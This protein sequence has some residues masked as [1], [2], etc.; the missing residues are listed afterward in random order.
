MDE[1]TARRL[2]LELMSLAK[3]A[4]LTTI[5]RDGYPETR[6]ISN[7]RNEEMFG[8]LSTLFAEHDNDF[9]VYFSTNTSSNKVAQIRANP[10]VSVYFC[11]PEQWRGL[12]LGG[13]M[14][15]SNDPELKKAIWQD[16]WELY[17]PTGP[18]DPGYSI[19]KLIPEIA[20]YY[21]QL[22]TTEFRFRP[23]P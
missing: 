14:E 12:M 8:G 4:C 7:L 6:A 11:Q 21:H 1:Q 23:K 13:N 19:L 15:V 20:K 9:L 2:S 17:Y 22:D 10:R 5:A 16:G 3:A 18:A